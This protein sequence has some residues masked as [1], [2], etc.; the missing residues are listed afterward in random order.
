MGNNGMKEKVTK[1]NYN[2]EPKVCNDSKIYDKYW[3]NYDEWRSYKEWYNKREW[4]P[5]ALQNG[6]ITMEEL[7]KI[8]NDE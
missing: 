1:I 6:D 4:L 3:L 5:I 2:D 7:L 8:L